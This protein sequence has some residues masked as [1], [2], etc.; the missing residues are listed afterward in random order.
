MV[1]E[2]TKCTLRRKG[3]IIEPEL[4]YRMYQRLEDSVVLLLKFVRSR[5]RVQVETYIIC[6]NKLNSFKLLSEKCTMFTPWEMYNQNDLEGQDC[7]SNSQTPLGSS[8]KHSGMGKAW[9]QPPTQVLSPFL[10]LFGSI[11]C[12]LLPS[13]ACVWTVEPTYPSSIHD[14]WQ[15]SAL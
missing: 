6:L 5:T 1:L 4:A 7:L 9:P 13:S 15:G 11:L 8:P 10:P 3:F 12:L 2:R 14:P